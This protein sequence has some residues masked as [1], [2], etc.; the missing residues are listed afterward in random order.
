MGSGY[1]DG[2][3]SGVSGLVAE[4]EAKSHVEFLIAFF[5]SGTFILLQPPKRKRQENGHAF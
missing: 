3:P 1:R 5:F 2:V 4:E